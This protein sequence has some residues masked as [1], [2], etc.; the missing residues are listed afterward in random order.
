MRLGLG[1]KPRVGAKRR[2]AGPV[3]RRH[4]RGVES[5]KIKAVAA[6]NLGQTRATRHE[7]GL[8]ALHRFK[9]RK[10]KAFGE[11]WK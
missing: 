4:A 9:H 11:R 3:D 2:H 6:G 10:S 1:G 5:I 8:A 7:D